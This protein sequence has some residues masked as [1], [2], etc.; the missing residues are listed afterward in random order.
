M[1]CD[2]TKFRDFARDIEAHLGL[3]PGPSY[4]LHRIKLERGWTLKNLRWATR[5][6]VLLD[7]KW[8]RLFT[9]KG[10]KWTTQEFADHLGVDYTTIHRRFK[11]G[12]KPK[13]CAEYY[14]TK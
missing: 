1:P 12:W 4:Y 10:K 5:Q 9:Y 2:W 14:G 3:P 6:E 7:T 11:M 13:Q 8:T